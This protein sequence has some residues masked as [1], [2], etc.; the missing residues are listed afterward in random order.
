MIVVADI[1]TY[2]E[3]NSA[4]SLKLKKRLVVRN[5]IKLEPIHKKT[6]KQQGDWVRTLISENIELNKKQT[7][8]RKDITGK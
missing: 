8:N 3:M 4:P 6:H 5:I 7:C 2:Q 1:E